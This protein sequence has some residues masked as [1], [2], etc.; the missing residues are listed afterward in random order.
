[1]N[2]RS[3]VY[4]IF[5]D[6]ESSMVLSSITALAIN[7]ADIILDK[8]H[9]RGCTNPVFQGDGVG[10]IGTTGFVLGMVGGIHAGLVVMTSWCLLF[11]PDC[12]KLMRALWTWSTYMSLLC[13]FH[14]L[15]FFITAVK[16]PKNLS[17]DSFVITHGRSYT[18]AA[19]KLT[20]IVV[21]LFV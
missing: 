21:I 19:S 7:L 11:V 18:I 12:P 16:Q 8:L 17:F 1:M 5:A 6:I 15:E 3:K 4:L 20:H 9:F 2:L 13:L 10:K 14:F